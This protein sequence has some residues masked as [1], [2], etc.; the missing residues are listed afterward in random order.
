MNMKV[1]KD[2][3]DALLGRAGSRLTLRKPG[4]PHLDFEMQE[5]KNLNR[6]PLPDWNLQQNRIALAYLGDR[7]W[8]SFGMKFRPAPLPVHALQLIH[9]HAPVNTSFVHKAEEAPG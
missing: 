2:K 9:K 5:T 6:P 3:F 1:D 7:D 4:W 8:R